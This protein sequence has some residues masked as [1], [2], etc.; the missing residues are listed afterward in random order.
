MRIQHRLA[1][2]WLIARGSAQSVLRAISIPEHRP[3]REPMEASRDES[4]TI[5]GEAPMSRVHRPGLAFL[6]PS[7]H[8][9]AMAYRTRMVIVLGIFTILGGVAFSLWRE[10][11]RTPTYQGKTAAQWFAR[12]CASQVRYW[13]PAGT[14]LGAIW[15]VRL[16][17]QTI[18]SLGML[19][20]DEAS[21]D[22][23]LVALRALG[24]NAAIYLAREIRRPE[25]TWWRRYTQLFGKLPPTLQR[26]APNPPIPRLM[27]CQTANVA[28]QAL[29][30]NG[31]CAIP[32]LI[33][34][35]K[36]P[37]TFFTSGSFHTLHTLA[38]LPVK[39]E[40]LEPVLSL[41]AK[42]G[43]YHEAISLVAMLKVNTPKAADILGT[44]FETAD[45]G[46]KEAITVHLRHNFRPAT[47][48]LAIPHLLSTL[49]DGDANQRYCVLAVCEDL[50]TNAL[51][52]LPAVQRLTN[53][54]SPMVRRAAARAVRRIL[55]LLAAPVSEVLPSQ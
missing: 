2:R 9:A 29:G 27:V 40:D 52:A 37:G 31:A 13:S 48:A 28:L 3:T 11:A 53:D 19:T 16:P 26:L 39:W 41:W 21:R 24:T 17:V 38:G 32:A 7:L 30:T 12:F 33:E 55:G 6:Q 43:Q 4:A 36:E 49:A 35:L 50:G 10:R 14:P 47:A 46:T 22:P 42:R 1:G 54:P 8:H 23:N 20:K 15:P 44:M 34:S 18:F 25:P 5:R 45:A 51:P